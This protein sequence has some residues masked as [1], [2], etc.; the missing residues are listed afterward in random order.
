MKLKLDWA[1]AHYELGL[2]Y[3]ETGAVEMATG[4]QAMLVELNS[5]LAEKL[6]LKIQE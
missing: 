6:L 2:L 4:E 1:A 3:L 5:K